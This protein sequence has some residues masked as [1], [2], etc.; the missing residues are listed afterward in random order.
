MITAGMTMEEYYESYVY[1]ECPYNHECDGCWFDCGDD[2][3]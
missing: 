3:E 1:T 2:D